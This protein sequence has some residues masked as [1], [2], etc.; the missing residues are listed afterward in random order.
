MQIPLKLLPLYCYSVTKIIFLFNRP[1]DNG[2]YGKK[3]KTKHLIVWPA[4]KWHALMKER[5]EGICVRERGKPG[6]MAPKL[7]SSAA[8]EEPWGSSWTITCESRPPELCSGEVSL[9]PLAV[10]DLRFVAGPPSPCLSLQ[11]C[12]CVIHNSALTADEGGVNRG[13]FF[14]C[15]IK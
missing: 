9:P 6:Q 4:T 14:S 12:H 5:K 1:W 15:D 10:L 8:W 3:T 7:I 2:C 11:G 13:F